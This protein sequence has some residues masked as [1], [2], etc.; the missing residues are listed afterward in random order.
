MAHTKIAHKTKFHKHRK[1]TSINGKLST[2]KA[3]S[4]SLISKQSS[5]TLTSK[6][7]SKLPKKKHRKLS[8]SMK[9]ILSHILSLFIPS[10]LQSACSIWKLLKLRTNRSPK[11]KNMKMSPCSTT[12]IHPLKTIQASHFKWSHLNLRRFQS[13]P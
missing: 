9:K 5:D 7:S 4:F 6:T 11:N 10:K 2:L 13:R 1:K 3:N 12:W 8:K